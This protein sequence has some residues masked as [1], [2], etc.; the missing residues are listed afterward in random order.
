MA[1]KLAENL[2]LAGIDDATRAILRESITLHR[3]CCHN[4]FNN[5]RTSADKIGA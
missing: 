2:A 5:R 4:Y 3:M 1:S